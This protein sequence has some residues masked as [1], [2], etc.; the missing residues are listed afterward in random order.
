MPA[1]EAAV[2][3]ESGEYV[4]ATDALRSALE[5]ADLWRIRWEL[6]RTYLDARYYTEALGEFLRCHERRGEGAAMFLDDVPT[7]RYLV[8]LPYWTAR[9]Q[10][11]LGMRNA[12]AGNFER[13]LILRPQGELADDARQRMQ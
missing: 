11:S 12:A 4:S 10:S 8:E 13:F 7:W 5:L 9:A 3:R 6:G 1:I 2:L